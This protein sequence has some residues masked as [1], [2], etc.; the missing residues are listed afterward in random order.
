L[1]LIPFWSEVK[2]KIDSFVVGHGT[3]LLVKD[4]FN[5]INTNMAGMIELV[6]SLWH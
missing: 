1:C 5:S 4:D 2:I 6:L 3:L